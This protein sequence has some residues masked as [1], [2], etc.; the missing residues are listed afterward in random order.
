MEHITHILIPEDIAY[1]TNLDITKK[2]I[3]SL[4][5]QYP[6][7][8]NKEIS[9]I[10]NISE[11]QVC[12]H[13]KDMAKPEEFFK[14]RKAKY[15]ESFKQFQE[16]TK[17]FFSPNNI[18]PLQNEEKQ[19]L[20]NPLKKSKKTLKNPLES[21]EHKS[22]VE[23]VIRFLNGITSQ[24]VYDEKQKRILEIWT[25]TDMFTQEELDNFDEIL[26][27]KVQEFQQ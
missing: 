6:K 2:V 26:S 25:H 4:K 11:T 16:N 1:D 8:T 13:K 12:H 17:E 7:I 10:L 3:K 9:R 19:T 20:K 21:L 24:E 5:L 27:K 14:Q 22:D 23:R 15:K 18:P